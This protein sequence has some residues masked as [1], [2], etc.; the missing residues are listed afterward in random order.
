MNGAIAAS[1]LVF[2]SGTWQGETTLTGSLEWSGGTI[3]QA[4]L[5]LAAGGVVTLSGEGEKRLVGD[6]GVITNAG[7]VIW[8]GGPFNLE[9]NARFVNLPGALFD[10]RTDTALL[11]NGGGTSIFTN[12]GTYRKSTGSGTHSID[13]ARFVNE[14]TVA[15]ESGVM[16]FG[17]GTTVSA[18]G[19]GNS[20]HV[21]EAASMRFNSTGGASAFRDTAF[22]GPEQRCWILDREFS[23]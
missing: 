9:N 4:R 7:T 19:P 1:H 5:T 3:S 17:T 12:Q 6:P 11:Q 15:A 2:A 8:T 14:G 20:F 10:V 16:R 13:I 18:S 22:S 21:E 23:H